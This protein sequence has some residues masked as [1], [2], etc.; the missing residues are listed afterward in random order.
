MKETIKGYIK[1]CIKILS[2]LIA[3]VVLL[4][5][6]SLTYFSKAAASEYNNKYSETMS[7]YNEPS[8]S[9][10]IVAIGN[11]DLYSGF[12]PSVIWE[13]NGYTSTAIGAPRQTP[14]QSFDLLREALDKQNAKVVIVECDMLYDKNPDESNIES[15]IESNQNSIDV[16]FDYLKPESFEEGIN[17]ELPIFMFHD[18]WKNKKI[19][20][21]SN[22]NHGY[23][24]S[25]KI[26]PFLVSDAF[27]KPTEKAESISKVYKNNLKSLVSFCSKKDAKVILTTF[28]SPSSWNYERHNAVQQLAD[29]IEAPFIDFNL[30][31][32]EI[33]IDFNK[34]FRD[35]GNHLNY[36]GAKKVSQ[37]LGNFIE[38]N[39]QLD[40]LRENKKYNYWH[41]NHRQF[42]KQL[43]KRFV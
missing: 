41:D 10:Q 15:N 19:I 21:K 33:G 17:N 12:C 35:K 23:K 34:D 28:P 4:Q 6:L 38:N 16:V 22:I 5:V 2:F 30:L 14:S 37:Y 13:Q 25:N 32:D 7:F 1:P 42:K 3:F 36:Y 26:I 11:S 20:S 39:Y 18:R 9:L 24:Y 40:N 43:D 29:E 31:I 27:M 8:N